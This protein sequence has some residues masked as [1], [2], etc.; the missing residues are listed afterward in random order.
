MSTEDGL[1][2]KQWNRLEG[3]VRHYGPTATS[4]QDLVN[5]IE[6]P[7][8]GMFRSGMRVEFS[9][10]EQMARLCGFEFDEVKG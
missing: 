10:V 9:Y 1:N 3:F 8:D 6:N 2:A 5:K 7:P 4:M